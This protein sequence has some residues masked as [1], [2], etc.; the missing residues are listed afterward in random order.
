MLENLLIG[1]VT[2]IITGLA[3]W[4]WDRIRFSRNLNRKSDFFGI[5]PSEQVL[6]IMNQ[7]P[8][9]PHRMSHGDVETLVEVA[10][11][12]HEI[13]GEATIAPFDKI[14]E[15]A[16]S[17]TEFCIGGPDSNERTK[18]HL[19]NFLKG[20][21]INPYS[22]GT[23]DSIAILTKGEIFRFERDEKEYAILAKFRPASNSHPVLLVCGQTSKTNRAAGYYLGQN[24]DKSLRKKFGNG[25]FCLIL[26][27][28]SPA[29]Y[30]YK[31]VELAK[32]VTD[33][34]FTPDIE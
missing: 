14:L 34:A 2:S 16:G 25:Q 31:A 22:P 3:V 13:R 4:L 6:I 7:H 30:G 29:S 28:T 20:I 32:D 27:V 24:Y 18:A 5:R 19:R 9:T 1:I 23:P 11:I 26:K 8:Q 17:V 21:Y 15:P 33:T 10:R 12:V